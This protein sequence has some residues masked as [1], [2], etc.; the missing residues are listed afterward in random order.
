MMGE[1]GIFEWA[2]R[3]NCEFGVDKFQLLDMSR[4]RVRHTFLLNRRVPM[5]RSNLTLEEYTIR[6]A[7]QEAA[8]LAKARDWISRFT[9]LARPSQG[10][11]AKYARQLYKA[12]TLPRIMYGAEI[13]L[14]PPRRALTE[15][16]RSKGMR[17]QR[18]IVGKLAATQRQAMLMVTSGMQSTA[19]NVLEVITGYLPFHLMV[20]RFRFKAALQLAALPPT[21]PLFKHVQRAV[22]R[23]VQRHHTP[24]HALLHNFRISP[25]NIEKIQATRWN[26][27]WKSR[28]KWCIP[29]DRENAMEEECRDSN[30]V[31]VY[32]DGS[33]YEGG[34]GAAAAM[35][36]NGQRRE[37]A[38]LRLECTVYNGECTALA[39]GME[40]I[41]QQ[42]YVEK[43]TIY[44]DN[45]ASI[46]ALSS[47][48]PGPGHYLLDY[49]HEVFVKTKKKHTGLQLTV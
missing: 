1:D 22:V 11:T 40:L 21:H 2:R 29:K 3:H 23:D 6:S 28:V 7:E 37:A 48:C 15:Q 43:A 14:T 42:V 8:A 41:Q 39:M 36:S 35:M 30:R 26:A 24:I 34:I 4:K 17:T 19:S 49:F 38:R 12:I 16:Q 9:W 5:P 10:I 20:E 32:T 45:Q 31:K 13:Y 25:K 44:M 46:R 27:K 47:Q 18:A 33:G